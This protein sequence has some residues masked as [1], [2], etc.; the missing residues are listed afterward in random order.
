MPKGPVAGT[1]RDRRTMGPAMGNPRDA[2]RNPGPATRFP[3]EKGIPALARL[4]SL[5]APAV[6]WDIPGG[7]SGNLGL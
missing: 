2:Y 1:W 3:P 6:F 7:L 4:A 5:G